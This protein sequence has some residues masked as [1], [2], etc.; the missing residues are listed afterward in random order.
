M[1]GKPKR[2]AQSSSGAHASR[3]G[4]RRAAPESAISD[5]ISASQA[6]SSD[7]PAWISPATMERVQQAAARK[8]E[9]EERFPQIRQAYLD[10]LGRAYLRTY[11]LLRDHA[12]D[13]ERG[14]VETLSTRREASGDD[15]ERRR[16]LEEYELVIRTVRAR[17]EARR[18]E[19][20]GDDELAES[21]RQE[22]DHW[23][24]LMRAIRTAMDAVGWRDFSLSVGTDQ[25]SIHAS[26]W[27]RSDERL[28][29]TRADFQRE[30]GAVLGPGRAKALRITFARIWQLTEDEA[31][32]LV[33]R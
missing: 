9:R 8:R 18:A 31:S 14:A 3:R 13:G 16:L 20:D 28:R 19:A 22:H 7:A 25:R 1:S 5:T 23:M 32:A 15:V 30:L 11:R 21:I 10:A 29:A 33:G 4:G 12:T 24:H 26:Y 2:V 27:A 6:T 17:A